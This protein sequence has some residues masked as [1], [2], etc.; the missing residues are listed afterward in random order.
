MNQFYRVG[1]DIGSTTVKIVFT[2]DGNI[3]FSDYQRH[4]ADILNSL[5]TSFL[6]AKKEVGDANISILITGSAGMG[7]A[8]KFNIP[9]KQE[10][11]AAAE[12]IKQK[13]SDI[14][15]LID[16]GGEDAKMIFFEEG[17]VPDIRMNGS[18]AGGTGA[19]IDQ[20]ASLLGIEVLEINKL[21]ANYKN[22]YPI[23]SR[24]GVFTKTDVQNLI[25][26]NVSREDIAASIFNAVALQTI[27]SLAR[28]Y[29][30][31]PK[32]FFCGGPLTF[33]TELPKFF[34]SKLNLKKE[35]CV[36]SEHSQ[37]IPA[38]GCAIYEP[39]GNEQRLETKISDFLHLIQNFGDVNTDNYTERLDIL[40]NDEEEFILWNKEKEKTKIKILDITEIDDNDNFY[41][42]ID[43]GSTTTKIVVIN[44][45]EDIVF[46]YYNKNNGKPLDAIVNGF[47]KLQNKLDETGKTM[48]ITKSAVTG[49]GEDLVKTAFNID[50][51]IVE[52]IAHYTAARKFKDNVSFIL[53]IGGQDMKAIFVDNGAINRLEV[54]EACSSGCGSFIEGFANSLKYSV[55]DFANCACFATHPCDLGTRCT[56][57]MNSKV[58]Q[59]LREGATISDI[60]AGLAYSVVKNCLYKVLK[61]KNLAE[62]GCNIVVQGGTFRNKSIIKALEK[63]VE[64][65]VICSN[66]PELMGAY[67]ASLYANRT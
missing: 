49:Y 38:W 13:Y 46:S 52:T 36:M 19:F 27:T 18:C 8:E 12:V 14:K 51:G 4:N 45:N 55:S 21:A 56:V 32:V 5:S 64:Q 29:D 59:F 66:I 3:V 40:F 9:F 53:D 65:N 31:V 63:L 30:I 54:N 33:L 28:G 17:K 10:V 67:G 44:S 2:V 37:Y 20:V 43:S 1:I 26:K 34:M 7:V 42:G 48:K 61:I 16:I 47:S 11:L 6:K 25:A 22:I 41:C 35:D 60:A 58:K 39:T 50:Y 62:L 57:F 23:A 24:C 15:T